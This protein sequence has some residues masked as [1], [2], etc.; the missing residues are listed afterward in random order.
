MGC[1]TSFRVLLRCA[2]EL[3]VH[4]P[5]CATILALMSEEQPQ[6]AQGAVD[7]IATELLG[8]LGGDGLNENL[9]PM[10]AKNLLHFLGSMVAC[11]ALSVVDL[12]PDADEDLPHRTRL[13]GGFASQVLEPIAAVL[14]VPTNTNA[15]AA[16]NADADTNLDGA[17]KS[18]DAME[19]MLLEC[20]G[21]MC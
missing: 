21:C 11:K 16:T 14:K 13:M 18:G 15:N 9:D 19:E 5:F 1:H 20:S 8:S 3:P 6:F 10:K 12:P 2:S 7:T 17:D 4:A